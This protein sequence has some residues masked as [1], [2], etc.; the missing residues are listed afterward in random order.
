MFIGWRRVAFHMHMDTDKDMTYNIEPP[1]NLTAG[2]LRGLTGL[3]GQAKKERVR[4]PMDIACM[5]VCIII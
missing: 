4:S 1:W 5:Y 3:V 2:S